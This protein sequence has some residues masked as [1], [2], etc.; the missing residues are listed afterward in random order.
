M[1]A[2]NQVKITTLSSNNNAYDGVGFNGSNKYIETLTTASNGSDSI[3][4]GNGYYY[5]GTATISEGT[6]FGPGAVFTNR[7]VAVNKLNG[8]YAYIN[9]D[10]GNIVSQASTLTNGSGTE[11]K[12]TLTDTA[13]RQLNYPLTLSIAEI[14]CIANKLVTVKCWFKKGH[15]TN[16]GA[17]LVFKA[18]LGAVENIATKA[19]DTNEEELT[20]TFTPTEAG[21]A[22]IE[23]WAYYVAAYSTVIIDKITV[24]QAD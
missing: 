17:K 10:G 20:V 8:N 14:A 4:P 19:N 11:W 21:V 16:I 9:T 3:S 15:A 5:I 23:A 7:F 6:Q 24:T 2:G 18:Q 1:G 12:F 13:N 22:E